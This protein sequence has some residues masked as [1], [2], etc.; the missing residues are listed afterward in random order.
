MTSRKHFTQEEDIKLK[1][2]VMQFGDQN[3]KEISKHMFKRSPRQCRERYKFYLS[4]NLNNMIWT[5]E[6]DTYL[7]ILVSYYG[8]KWSLISKFFLG[9]TEINVKCRYYR[10]ERQKLVN[11]SKQQTNKTNN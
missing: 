4:P 1:S 7:Q 5:K 6:E 3:W 9:R 2:L 10:L 11:L 8:N